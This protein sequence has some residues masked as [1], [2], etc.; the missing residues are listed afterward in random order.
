LQ[1]RTLMKHAAGKLIVFDAEKAAVKTDMRLALL[2]M[3]REDK[4]PAAM[5]HALQ[6]IRSSQK[7]KRAL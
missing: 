3:A 5:K 6:V 7:R 1:E 2:K 4:K